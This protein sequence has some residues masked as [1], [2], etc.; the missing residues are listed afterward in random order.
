MKATTI[1]GTEI[2]INIADMTLSVPSKNIENVTFRSPLPSGDF[3]VMD[4]RINGKI[5]G[6]AI[7]KETASDIVR[8]I[9]A[10][11]RMA[12]TSDE[13]LA[14]ERDT[15]S[16]KLAAIIDQAHEEHVRRIE[17]A[18][19][20]GVIAKPSMDW[21]AEEAAAR[22]ALAEFDAA[23]PEIIAKIKADKKDA[24]EAAMWN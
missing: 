7:S 21:D 8:A 3:W 16:C 1:N 9:R 14:D 11:E 4:I 23:H 22:K 10:S 17:R 15:L 19:A 12:K 13:V 6:V 18:S 5:A 2:T 24:T 20:T